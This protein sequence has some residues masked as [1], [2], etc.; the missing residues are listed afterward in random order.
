VATR[1]SNV[2]PASICFLL[3][4]RIS[5]N[6]YGFQ[7]WKEHIVYVIP[8]SRVLSGFGVVLEGGAIDSDYNLHEYS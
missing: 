3:R 5:H 4:V 7:Q 2:C 1:L 6:I 8:E